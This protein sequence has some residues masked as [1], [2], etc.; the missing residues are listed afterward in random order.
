M[1]K[2]TSPSFFVAVGFVVLLASSNCFFALAAEESDKALAV[3]SKEMDKN[4]ALMGRLGRLFPMFSK[5]FIRDASKSPFSFKEVF[6]AVMKCV[7]NREVAI[8]AVIGWGLVPLTHGLYD[9]YTDLTHPN[10]EA[11]SIGP[12]K[13]WFRSLVTEEEKDEKNKA[14]TKGVPHI[15][16][17]IKEK[18][19][20]ALVGEIKPFK[21]TFSF[22][23]AD[24]ISQASKIGIL[25]LTVDVS[26]ASYYP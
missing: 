15:K 19:H 5:L 20:H 13:G 8:F 1:G 18:V 11:E 9:L 6:N 4:A 21:D 24:H 12:V 22:L 25:V 17:K 26:I 10:I 7:D 3:A 2:S 16:E 14:K 23:V